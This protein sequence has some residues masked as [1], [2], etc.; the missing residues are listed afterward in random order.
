MR[1]CLSA[2]Y[3]D[4]MAGDPN[5]VEPIGYREQVDD[6]WIISFV[7]Q[8]IFASIASPVFGF[9]LILVPFMLAPLSLSEKNSLSLLVVPL[10][11]VIAFAGGYWMQGYRP[12]AL[13]TGKWVWILPWFLY[14]W[15]F[16]DYAKGRPLKD[17]L[18][19][20]FWPGPNDGEM[21]LGAVIFGIPALTSLTYIAGLVIASRRSKSA[22]RTSISR[23]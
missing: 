22:P 11:L 4:L 1:W 18:R 21:G 20:G 14:L 10:S 9:I 2:I 23:F 13:R 7:G 12:S 15:N 3:Y 8:Q 19:I 5:P 6:F 17:A 16:S